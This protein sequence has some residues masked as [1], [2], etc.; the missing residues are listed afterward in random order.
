MIWRLEN[1]VYLLPPE[2]LGLALTFKPGFFLV[3]SSWIE[4]SCTARPGNGQL[5]L[6]Y[7]EKIEMQ[8]APAQDKNRGFLS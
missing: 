4:G 5:H 8:H 7:S 6:V 1:L 3:A 2:N